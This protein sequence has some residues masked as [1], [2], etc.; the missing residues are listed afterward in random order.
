MTAPNAPDL[1]RVQALF[2]RLLTAPEGVASGAGQ[3]VRSGELAS[4]DLSFL[5]RPDPPERQA[6]RLDSVERLDIYADMYFYRLRDAL[7]EDFPRLVRRIGDTRFHN[8]VTDYLLA[9]PSRHFSLRE[10]GRAL[11]EFARGHALEREFP[12]LADL[13][14]LEWARVDVFDE[15][16]AETLSQQELLE[17]GVSAPDAFRIGLIPAA[18]LEVVDRRVLPLWKH[19]DADE[20]APSADPLPDGDGASGF[21]LIWRR[22]G[23]ILHRSLPA[24][25][26]EWLRAVAAGGMSLAELGERLVGAQPDDVPEQQIAERFAALLSR[27]AQE[28]L[29]VRLN[30]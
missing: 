15:A 5:I 24:D 27:W 13:A 29:L 25:E 21:V 2:W 1:S 30:S 18:R 11:P 22:D 12:A 17:G 8:L 20:A 19:L 28:A 10:L 23:A 9:H 7:A 3:L 16:D 14:A 4:E 26:A 6:A